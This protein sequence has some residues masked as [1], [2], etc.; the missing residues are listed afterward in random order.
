MINDTSSFPDIPSI[1]WR[2]Q[3]IENR[4]VICALCVSRSRSPVCQC[5]NKNLVA[6]II[7]PVLR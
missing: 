7:R 3:V 1:H 2:E 6:A 4:I 5:C